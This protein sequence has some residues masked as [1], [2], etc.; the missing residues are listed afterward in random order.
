MKPIPAP[1]NRDER[2]EE[3]TA[4]TASDLLK[5]APAGNARRRQ[6]HA[7][8]N[9]AYPWLLMASTSIAVFFGL[10]YINKDVVVA[11]DPTKQLAAGQIGETGP[12]AG[13]G[14]ETDAGDGSLLPPADS[15]PGEAAPASNAAGKASSTAISTAPIHSIFE[16]TN[17]RVQHILTARSDDGHV[18]RIDLE[19]P[20]LYPSRQLRWTP[21]QIAQAESLMVR[22]MDYQLKSQ[23]LRA[24]GEQLLRD[25][26]SLI[27]DSIPA[28]RL[29]AD[30]PSIPGNQQHAIVNSGPVDT[31]TQDAI[32]IEN[33]D[34]P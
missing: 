5:I 33:E 19:V 18:S 26:N 12:L 16:E 11:G 21:T 14:D 30:S 6:A 29:R 10:M 20:V 4:A 22:L 32:E 27:G 2:P 3:A 24:E 1:S 17:M 15:L 13:T 8:V 9:R 34:Q 25:W 7:T 31:T 28:P 23:E